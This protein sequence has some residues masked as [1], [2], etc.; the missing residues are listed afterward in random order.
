MKKKIIPI[1]ILSTGLF[2][3]SP[4]IAY[5]PHANSNAND[6]V[7]APTSALTNAPQVIIDRLAGL[8]RYE[9]AKIISEYYAQG[10]VK[11]VV[12]TTGNDF[13]DALSA[14]V[15]AHQK[16]APILLVNST[17]DSSKES[18]TYLEQHLETEGTVYIIGGTGVIGPEFEARLKNLGFT[19]VVRIAGKDRYETSYLIADTII[20]QMKEP[21]VKSQGSS[22]DEITA[23]TV[24]ISSGE[25]Y[26][27]ALSI[28]SFAAN[29]GWP[30]LL[31][32]HDTLPQEV[33]TFL[34]R[35]KPAQLYIT[36]GDGA[37]SENVLTE[38]R[39]L[40]P[41]VHIERLAGTSRFD[42]NTN[43]A[44]TFAPKPLTI[45]LATGYGFA[46]AM[47]GSIVAAKTGDPILFVDPSMSSLPK[48]V[49]HYLSNLYANHLS[50]HI[51]SF[52]G[53]GVIS[54]DLVKNASELMSGK[55]QETSLCFIPDLT[56]SVTL[57]N[58][59]SLPLKIQARLYNS[60]IIEVPV[61]WNITSIDTSHVGTSIFEGA[62]DGYG[63]TVKLTL[64]VKEPLPIAE[65]TTYFDSSLINR[66]ENI[67]L[68][69]EALD[70]K[71]L[72]SGE[73][74]S[75]NES[76]GERTADKGY[77]EALIIE[78]DVFTPGLGGG[79]CQVS[80]TLYNAVLLAQLEIVER[81]RHSLPISYVPL[82]QDATVA[83]PNLDFKFKNTTDD[84]LLIRTFMEGDTLT[85]KLYEGSSN[86]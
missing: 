22:M 46:D 43:I 84:Y 51:V 61:R 55:A 36:G 28:S 78:G 23:S 25:Q 77:K 52:G 35:R 54:D 69:A 38:I 68:A 42:T 27:D 75:F 45:Y 86:I 81:H 83:W 41:Q 85:F 31:S 62:V 9:T 19:K 59:Y 72:A 34:M 60:D 58:S 29:N 47:A 20:K 7:N 53:T 5:D 8:T 3:T 44:E 63:K 70:G 37:I 26:P 4:V 80:S 65:Y 24:V 74:F 2:M 79:I 39:N 1:L 71:R 76:V 16:E 15:L 40:I 48:S 50:P 6:S 67:R 13:A 73:L 64:T 10:K 21:L 12:L 66:T 49:A 14:S 33:K 56:A 17:V 32:T 57:N 82:D 11:N 30:I 18:F